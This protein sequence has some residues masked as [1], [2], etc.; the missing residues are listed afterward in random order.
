MPVFIPNG[1]GLAAG[2]R[3]KTRYR[4]VDRSGV[5]VTAGL[6][7]A[8]VGSGVAPAAILALPLWPLPLLSL[9]SPAVPFQD[10]SSICQSTKGE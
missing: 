6:A 3:A 7:D 2:G 5:T 1:T 4:L 9:T 8:V 10:S